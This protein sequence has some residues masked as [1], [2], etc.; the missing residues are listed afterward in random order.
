MGTQVR[1]QEAAAREE[2]QPGRIAQS[3]GVRAFLRTLT[4]L[5][6]A[7]ATVDHAWALD[8]SWVGP[9]NGYWDSA[10]NWN[11]APPNSSSDVKLGVFDAEFRSGTFVVN[12]PIRLLAK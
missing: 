9:N 11:P 12:M 2:V 5:A 7:F 1:R 10:T 8:V 6:A 4:L 3:F